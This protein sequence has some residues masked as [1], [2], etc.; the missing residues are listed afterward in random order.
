MQGTMIRQVLGTR[1]A[2]EFVIPS[3]ARGLLFLN[4]L[5]FARL[6][7]V[8]SLFLYCS[9]ARGRSALAFFVAMVR[10]TQSSAVLMS[11]SYAR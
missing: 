9:G 1:R 5:Y 7:F 2:I 10:S 3:N 11:A 4:S 6:R 8:S